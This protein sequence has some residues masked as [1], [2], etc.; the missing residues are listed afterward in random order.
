MLLKS[1]KLGTG[2]GSRCSKGERGRQSYG[3]QQNVNIWILAA[4][5]RG[6]RFSPSPAVSVLK[7][8]LNRKCPVLCAL[9]LSLMATPHTDKNLL[10][11]DLV[12]RWTTCGYS[13]FSTFPGLL[14]PW[15]EKH[16]PLFLS[17]NFD[18]IISNRQ[19]YT[20]KQHRVNSLDQLKDNIKEW[21]NR[22]RDSG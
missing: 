16:F 11:K 21:Q 2:I 20:Y 6:Q 15:K 17:L 22:Y 18:L 9:L 10:D 1:L 14:D 3:I 4:A 7:G 12:S 5:Q 19:K 8:T 13:S